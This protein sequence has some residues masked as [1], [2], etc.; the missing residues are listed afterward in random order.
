[1]ILNAITP[2]LSLIG[3]DYF[4][5]FGRVQRWLV[6]KQKLVFLQIEANRLY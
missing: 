6:N 1:M 4:D 3:F 5:I 2:N